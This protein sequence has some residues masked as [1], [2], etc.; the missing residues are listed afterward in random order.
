MKKTPLLSIC[1]PTWNRWY[2]LQHTLKSIIDY[3]EFKSWDVEIVISD[4]ASIDETEWEIKKMCVKW[5]NIKYYRNNKN[6]WA[7]ENINKAYSLWSWKYLWCLSSHTKVNHWSLA[8][9]LSLLAR[10]QPVLLINFPWNSIYFSSY[11]DNNFKKDYNIYIFDNMVNYF[12][13]LWNQLLYDK[14][15]FDL[16]NQLFSNMWCPIMDKNYYNGTI[17]DIIIDRWND[18]FNSH[19]FIHLF[20]AYYNGWEKKVVLNNIPAFCLVDINIDNEVNELKTNWSRK[21]RI[22][23][24]DIHVFTEY[25]RNKYYCDNNVLLFLKKLDSFWTKLYYVS[26]IPFIDSLKKL[27]SKELR[28]KVRDFF[29]NPKF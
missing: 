17:K 5:K 1:I 10:F 29:A 8:R 18:F 15:S 13:Y 12:N 21:D 26:N 11:R 4:N 24:E 14:K 9:I 23:M 2:S 27:F 16:T 19:N 6:V 3:D 28:A 7:M 20:T 22:Y 25:I